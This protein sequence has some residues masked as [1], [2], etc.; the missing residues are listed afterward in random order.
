MWVD[1]TDTDYSNH[2]NPNK[3]QFKKVK[4]ELFLRTI[5]PKYPPKKDFQNDEDYYLVCRAVTY[6]TAL[7]DIEKQ[8]RKGIRGKK[9]IIEGVR[10]FDKKKKR[11]SYFIESASKEIKELEKHLNDNDKTNPLWDE[12]VRYINED[13]YKFDNY[14]YKITNIKRI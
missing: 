3:L 10:Y 14:S 5:K 6:N 1:I 11:P 12:A 7:K 2:Y 9:Y 4:C 8:R 13:Y